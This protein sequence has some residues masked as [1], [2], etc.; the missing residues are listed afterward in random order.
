MSVKRKSNWYIYF[1]AFGVTLAFVLVAIIAF[2]WYLFPDEK[3]QTGVNS[4]GEIVQN[5]RPTE[6][7]NFN[8]MFMLSQGAADNPDLFVL[9]EYN[10]VENRIVLIPL[11]SGISVRSHGKS[12]PN[13]YA[14]AGGQG[15]V[16]VVKDI[17]GVKCDSY[18]MFDRN[19]FTS[20]V[21]SFGNVKYNVPKTVIISDNFSAEII[22]AG[23]K[24]F[25]A[26]TLFSYIMQV[27]FGEGE[28]Y[29]FNIV[30][31]IISELINQNYR[32]LDNS[33]LNSLF[34]SIYNDCETNASRQDFTSHLASFLYMVDYGVSPAEYYIPYG[35]YTNDGGFDI[36]DNSIIT[37]K[38]KAGLI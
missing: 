20:L 25:S 15:V 21:Q 9:I 37:I 36:S 32:E 8:A 16:D 26:D 30:G 24:L 23:E 22:N 7:D 2:K 13:V 38:Q 34:N 3:T 29:R 14:A 17:T 19:S 28:L 11:S 27:D 18:A 5:Y 33:R 12:L 10:A 31:D 4:N 6:K 35:E 1:T